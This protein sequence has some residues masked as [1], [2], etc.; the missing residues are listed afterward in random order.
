MAFQALV[1]NADCGPSTALQN[2]NKQFDRDRGVQA[3][4]LPP[5]DHTSAMPD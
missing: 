2:L 3:V 4:R 5:S 1:N